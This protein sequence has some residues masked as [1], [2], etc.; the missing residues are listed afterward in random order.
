MAD[1]AVREIRVPVSAGRSSV[2]TLNRHKSV[3]AFL[4]TL[5]LLLVI[6]GLVAYPAGYAVN[7]AMLNKSMQHFVGWS[8]F[9]FLFRRPTFWMVV[10]QSCLFAITAVS[11]KAVVGFVVAHFVHN[12]PDKGQR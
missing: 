10:E 3:T 2:R 7:L 6:F 8:N 5:P 1:A 4:F 12:L 9:T 11:F